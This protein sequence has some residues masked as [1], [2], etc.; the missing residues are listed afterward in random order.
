MKPDTSRRKAKPPVDRS[1]F[2]S[3]VLVLVFVAEFFVTIAAICWAIISTRSGGGG[4]GNTLRLDFP[5]IGWLAFMLIV[6]AG[7]ISLARMVAG[8]GGVETPDEEAKEQAR[9]QAWTNHLP[10]RALRLYRVAHNAPVF[11]ICL[12]L[13][14]LGATLLAID[15]ALSLLTGVALAL[16]PYMPYFIGALTVFAVAVAGLMAWFRYKHNKLMA[17]YAFRREVLERTGIILVDDTSKALLP[18]DGA[19]ER[20]TLAAIDM[21]AG[22]LPKALPAGDGPEA[23]GGP[24]APCEPD[25]DASVPAETTPSPD[26]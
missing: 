13:A 20:Y 3:S 14:A 10:E 26:A 17:E 25:V 8:R 12:A 21:S 7:I 19:A 23:H 22:A 24:C 5:W 15:S 2:W 16:V 18:P 6:P 11:V 1:E 4:A 9:E